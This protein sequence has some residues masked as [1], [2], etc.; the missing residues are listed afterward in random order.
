MWWRE[1]LQVQ[2]QLYDYNC[3]K[4]ENEK[5]IRGKDKC[6]Q[7]TADTKV[8]GVQSRESNFHSDIPK[9]TC[10]SLSELVAWIIP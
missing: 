3:K 7:K 4:Q 9:E 1:D 6:F 8:R 2:S 10:K 5:R